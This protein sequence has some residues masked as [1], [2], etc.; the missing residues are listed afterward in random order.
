MTVIVSIN[1]VNEC[2]TKTCLSFFKIKS[3]MKNPEEYSSY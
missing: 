3:R 2:V 1:K